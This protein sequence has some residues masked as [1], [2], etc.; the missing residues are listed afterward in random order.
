MNISL[1]EV[2]E[3]EYWIELL[4]KTDY[5]TKEEFE[6]INPDCSEVIKLLTAIIKSSAK[7]TPLN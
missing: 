5:L 2:A 1:K 3:S 6:N 7:P 4:F